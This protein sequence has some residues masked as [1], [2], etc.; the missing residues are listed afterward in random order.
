[1]IENSILQSVV[2]ITKQRDLD[3]LEC[4]LVATL[5]ELLPVVSVSILKS[6]KEDN[7]ASVE[8]VIRLDIDKKNED[9][10]SWSADA[11]LMNANG[12]YGECV[13][14]SKAITYKHEQGFSRLLFPISDDK[15]TIGCLVIDSFK[16]LSSHMMLIEGFVRIYE[17]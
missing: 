8:E 17:N 9:P 10:Y 7:A 12:H 13:N 5:A 2:D 14:H 4:S 1:M 11:V 3:S 16:D 6:V 15:H